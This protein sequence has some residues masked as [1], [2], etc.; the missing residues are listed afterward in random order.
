MKFFLAFLLMFS[1]PFGAFAAGSGA[2]SGGTPTP[3]PT[4]STTETPVTTT[5]KNLNNQLEEINA[6]LKAKDFSK[7]LSELVALDKEFTNNADINNL[8][9][10]ASRNLGQFSQS[11]RYYSKALQINPNH[12]G[13]LEYQGELFVKTNKIK[14]AK[15]NL[16]KL[17]QLCGTNC[18]EYRDL[19]KAISSR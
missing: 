13:A 8:L 1:M 19:K 4:K 17:K 3:E 5:K 10:F 18:D 2:G 7:A 14:A 16:A 11:A 9:G 15:K 6:M 12:I